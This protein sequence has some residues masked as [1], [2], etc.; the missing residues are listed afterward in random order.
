M[1]VEA[2]GQLEVQLDGGTLVRTTQGILNGD[3]DLEKG[4][5]KKSNIF[6]PICLFSKRF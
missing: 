4:N 3:V 2:L 6:I 1:Q 5:I